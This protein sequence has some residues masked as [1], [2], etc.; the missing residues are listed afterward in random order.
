MSEEEKGVVS[1]RT[2]HCKKSILENVGIHYVKSYC[3]TFLAGINRSGAGIVL[4]LGILGGRQ[5]QSVST[6]PIVSGSPCYY[7]PE[8]TWMGSILQDVFS[9]QAKNYFKS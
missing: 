8:S 2:G 5:G 9:S 1:V 3:L 4:R 6:S 7:H